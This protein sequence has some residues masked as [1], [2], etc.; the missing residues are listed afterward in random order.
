VSGPEHIPAIEVFFSAGI[1]FLF[2]DFCRLIVSSGFHGAKVS[3][4]SEPFV[5]GKAKLLF[6]SLS[7]R[8]SSTI[9]YSG[10]EDFL[11]KLHTN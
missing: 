11:S 5:R 9:I 6:Q 7:H 2:S 1:K 10:N 4:G 8:C 3:A